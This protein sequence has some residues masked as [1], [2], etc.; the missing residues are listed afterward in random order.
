MA[1]PHLYIYIYISLPWG[2]VAVP[3]LRAPQKMPFE[4]V[5]YGGPCP[6]VF[7]GSLL[8]LRGSVGARKHRILV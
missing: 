4:W 5:K 1:F 6:G 8:Q 3:K 2:V 7:D